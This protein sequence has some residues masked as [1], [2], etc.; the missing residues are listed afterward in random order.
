MIKTCYR[1]FVFSGDIG[2][3]LILNNLIVWIQDCKHLVIQH[4]ETKISEM[5]CSYKINN[6]RHKSVKL[7]WC[8]D[9]LQS[10]MQLML[11]KQL[12]YGINRMLQL[13]GWVQFKTYINNIAHA[14]FN[15]MQRIA[16]QLCK[17]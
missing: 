1:M 10:N 16:T 11:I 13:E 12:I 14:F 5:K 2:L 15:Y 3:K 7:V 4:W 8:E 6:C 9:F 17:V